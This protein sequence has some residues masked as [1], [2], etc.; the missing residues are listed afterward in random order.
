M[1]R[2]DARTVVDLEHELRAARARLADEERTLRTARATL[3]EFATQ[4]TTS[5]ESAVAPAAPGV[6]R[7]PR[8]PGH[9]EFE[10]LYRELALRVHPDLASDAAERALRTRVMAELNSA[11][12]TFDF[13]RARKLGDDWGIRPDDVD[14]DPSLDHVERLMQGIERVEARLTAV[15]ADAIR[16]RETDLYRLFEVV[17]AQQRAGLDVLGETAADLDVQIGEARSRIGALPL[18]SGQPE[19]ETSPVPAMRMRPLAVGVLLASSIA[20]GASLFAATPPS[21]ATIVANPATVAPPTPTAA[22]GTA[23]PFPFRVVERQQSSSGRTTTTVRIVIEGSPSPA[24]KMSTLAEA[25]RREIGP[26]EAVVV[27]AYRS[28]H[29]IGGPYTVGRA[30]MSVDG[31]GPG[32]DARTADGPDIGGIVG[33]IVV[34]L[35]GTSAIQTFAAPR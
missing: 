4:L 5:D 20:L 12:E 30:F 28:A 33:S 11:R 23:A 25:A 21:L 14:A 27:Y 16:L 34:D 13:E 35:G 22:P 24:E 29:E 17:T 6:K 15:A 7:P 26:R 19:T 9:T 31:R 18:L 8:P 10:R 2:V 1:T 32:G 3:H